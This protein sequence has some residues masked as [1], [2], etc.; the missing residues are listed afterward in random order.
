MNHRK[1][2]GRQLALLAVAMLLA[3]AGGTAFAK[4]YTYTESA[5]YPFD[6]VLNVPCANNG[7]GEDIAISGTLRVV[8]HTTIDGSG[9]SHT[10]YH[11]ASEGVTA[12]GL[13]TGDTYQVTGM[14]G[15]AINV[16]A[17]SESTFVDSFNIVGP[18]PGNNFL[19]HQTVHVTINANGEVTV[20]HEDTRVECK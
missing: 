8:I 16:T 7:V 2:W 19:F 17:G 20:S 1:H 11:A 5:E 12:V 6:A 18:G 4:A 9:G 14:T 13:I 10:T 3:A 15:H